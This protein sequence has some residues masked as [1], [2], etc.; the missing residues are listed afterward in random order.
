MLFL[1]KSPGQT[2]SKRIAPESPSTKTAFASQPA[3]KSYIV[4]R[5]YGVQ[6]SPTMRPAWGG[7]S[8][9]PQKSL[10]GRPTSTKPPAIPFVIPPSTYLLKIMA[11]HSIFANFIAP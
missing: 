10:P 8:L 3:R 2:Q 9:S 11:S 5:K 7:D 1:N 4:N 6:P